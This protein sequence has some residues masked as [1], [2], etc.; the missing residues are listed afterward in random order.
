MRVLQEG[1]PAPEVLF[2]VG[3][4]GA[5]DERA[6]KTTQS[7]ARLLAA[8]GIDSAVL[9]P[10]EK[11]TGDP[12]R[13]MGHEYL[14]QMLAEQNVETL[15]GAGVTKIVASCA[16][17]F[18]TLRERVPGLRRD[19][20]GRAPHAAALRAD[21][22][23]TAPAADRRRQDHVP[24]RLLPRAAQRRVRRA[25]RRASAARSR[26]C[27]GT[28]SARSAAAPAAPACGW[29]RSRPAST[30]R[31]SRRRSQRE[32]K[33]WRPRAPT[34]SSCSTTLEVEGVRGARRR[35]RDPPRRILDC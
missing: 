26:R 35:R 18:N 11:C 7:V 24:R 2:W 32:L 25:A 10:R 6:Q 12:A 19:V 29:R 27:R 16:H 9:G 5:F 33:P 28:A 15:N 20:R 13:R 31:G 14:F 23:G 3:C 34:A 30:T 17:C 22:G 21:R 4:A 1:D 8:A